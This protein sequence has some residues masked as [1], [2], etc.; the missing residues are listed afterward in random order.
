MTGVADFR[1]LDLYSDGRLGHAAI[2]CSAAI[3]IAKWAYFVLVVSRGIA[4]PDQPLL[5]VLNVI[6]PMQQRAPV[7]AIVTLKNAVFT[8]KIPPAK[9]VL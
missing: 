2:V 5:Q 9:P 7:A 8:Q 1:V 3:V 4:Y 6:W